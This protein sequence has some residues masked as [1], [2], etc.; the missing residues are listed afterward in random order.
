MKS[1]ALAALVLLLQGVFVPS[2]S[3]AAPIRTMLGNGY[4][5]VYETSS[6][7]LVCV[8]ETQGRE[9]RVSVSNDVPSQGDWSGVA[10]SAG[11]VF[12][13]TS[14]NSVKY[15]LMRFHSGSTSSEGDGKSLRG[16][17]APGRLVSASW[18][19]AQYG[20]KVSV[21][22]L[23]GNQEYTTEMYINMWGTSERL[24]QKKRTIQPKREKVPG[25]SVSLEVPPGFSAKW[26]PDSKCLA[27]VS[28]TGI[29]AGMMVHATEGGLD[30]DEFT[31]IFMRDI[32][33]ALGA[34]AM[35][36]V[37]SK[38]ITVG[39][40]MPGLLRIANSSRAGKKAT[41]AFVFFTSPK[42]TVVLLYLSPSENYDQ[43]A[44]LFYR[45]IGTVQ[46][47]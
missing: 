16:P 34:D 23:D 47:N 26:D 4:V 19:P 5:A 10:T 13:Y 39:G 21:V 8:S 27:L 25:S 45:L 42:N 6:R 40:S 2:A 3:T 14:G 17:V 36:V 44:N 46:L 18:K 15:V 7:D 33:A 1:T 20:A 37:A 38:N 11:P 24:S 43:Y 29:P 31:S 32:G 12:V 35:N 30:L 22:S 41:F 28:D 9:W